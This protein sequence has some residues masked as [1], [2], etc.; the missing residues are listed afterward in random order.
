MPVGRFVWKDGGQY[1]EEELKRIE[2]LPDDHAFFKAGML[3]GG[4]RIAAPTIQKVH[5]HCGLVR[6]RYR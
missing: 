4:K 1:L 6:E 3:G 2:E 5:V